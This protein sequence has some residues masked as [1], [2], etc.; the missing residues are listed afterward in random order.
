M[1]DDSSVPR[2]PDEADSV[3]AASVGDRAEAHRRG[4]AG[5]AASENCVVG[6][7]G[8]N[9]Q[10]QVKMPR[11]LEP[12]SWILIIS[13]ANLKSQKIRKS[14]QMN[15]CCPANILYLRRHG[16]EG[17]CRGC[18]RGGGGARG[19]HL[20]ERQRAYVLVVA[21]SRI[22][23]TARVVQRRRIIVHGRCR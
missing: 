3:S 13:M 4:M 16:R 19:S 8:K 20:A 1:I 17:R 11:M 10:V 14:N 15:V 5:K 2:V 22:A 12:E 7:G 9:N 21:L 23:S 18:R 6:W